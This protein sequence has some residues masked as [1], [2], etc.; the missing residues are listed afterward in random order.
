MTIATGISQP[1]IIV[2]NCNSRTCNG[3][4]CRQPLYIIAPMGAAN[5][6]SAG[7]LDRNAPLNKAPVANSLAVPGT[8]PQH[9]KVAAAA[10]EKNATNHYVLAAK[11]S[12]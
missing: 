1:P 6:K 10:L 12:P 9:R 2:A 4:R 3:V 8:L 7:C 11:A 5:S